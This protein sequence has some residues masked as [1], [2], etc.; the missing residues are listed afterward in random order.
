MLS[1]S[2]P[3]RFIR[4]EGVGSIEPNGLASAISAVHAMLAQVESM[5]CPS[6]RVIL[7]GFG[8]G[9]AL[10]LAAGRAYGRSLAG[11]V[12]FSGWAPVA[13]CVA[14]AAN[15]S[16]PILMCHGTADGTVS[17]NLLGESVALLRKENAA[18]HLTVCS[19]PGLG[20]TYSM[21]ELAKLLAFIAEHLPRKQH[22][23][24]EDSDGTLPLD[25]TLPAV[26]QPAPPEPAR[27]KS[28]IKIGGR[29][30]A[31]MPP[32]SLPSSNAPPTLA[33]SAAPAGGAPPAGGESSSTP[34]RAPEGVVV[35]ELAGSGG[36]GVEGDAHL[37]VVWTLPHVDGMSDLDL[38]ISS[39]ELSLLVKRE[40]RPMVVY[41]PRPIDADSARAKF[42][43]KMHTLTV[44]MRIS[45]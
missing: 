4:A 29:P 19:F 30:A 11:I 7:G 34:G 22:K 24:L 5:G 9:A 43:K 28:V 37:R 17:H 2:P 16:T 32:A 42:S 38:S 36:S 20:H 44:T 40:A 3:L 27:S 31:E 26:E 6:E 8:Q 33:A 41:L 12:M 10:A 14:S 21:S 15:A 1:L 39:E 13:P 45:S 18:A 35:S 25:G 23:T